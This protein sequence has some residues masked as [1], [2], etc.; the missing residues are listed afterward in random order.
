LIE[1]TVSVENH[2]SA[3]NHWQTLS[4]K[5]LSNKPRE[6]SWKTTDLLQIIDKLY[7][8]KFNRI[9]LGSTC[10]KSQI[11]CKSWTNFIRYNI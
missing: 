6:Y 3:A 9:N 7:Q 8:I 2:R 10:G 1:E 4:D 5:I 11:C